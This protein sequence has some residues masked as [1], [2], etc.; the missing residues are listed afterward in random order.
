MNPIKNQPS[1]SY[2]KAPSKKIPPLNPKINF[3][4]RK[5]DANYVYKNLNDFFCKALL[6]IEDE[7]LKNQIEKICNAINNKEQIHPHQLKKEILSL[8][9]NINDKNFQSLKKQFEEIRPHFF[10]KNIFTLVEKSN[11]FK[12]LKISDIYNFNIES[13]FKFLIEDN[14]LK[15]I[16]KDYEYLLDQDYFEEIFKI[17]TL[18]PAIFERFII[19][20]EKESFEKLLEKTIIKVNISTLVCINWTRTLFK[21]I[22]EHSK[23]ISES[24]KRQNLLFKLQDKM[25]D[26]EFY[27]EALEVIKMIEKPERI[28]ALKQFVNSSLNGVDMADFIKVLREN[29]LEKERSFLS[30]AA[31]NLRLE[32]REINKR[33]KERE[34]KL[35]N[36]D[37]E[38]I[39]SDDLYKTLSKKNFNIKEQ[40][41]AMLFELSKKSEKNLDTAEYFYQTLETFIV[42]DSTLDQDLTEILKS[43]IDFTNDPKTHEIIIQI[44]C[45]NNKFS[46]A[47]ELTKLLQNESLKQPTLNRISKDISYSDLSSFLKNELLD[48]IS[49]YI[50]K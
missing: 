29:N 47:I 8:L 50:K 22:A 35:K 11:S 10:F 31:Y 24:S 15:K 13:D 2:T 19:L 7:K 14:S 28:Q 4:L 33:K 27:P 36:E 5:T 6:S 17:K 38:T 37:E 34:E 32:W 12:N 20:N 42:P 43:L 39:A 48:L 16:I 41:K 46:I 25:F 26:K 21:K 9:E 23:I 3:S 1:S 49:S 30:G 45:D 40:I 18:V 44:A